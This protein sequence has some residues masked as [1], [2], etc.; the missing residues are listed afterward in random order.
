M[1]NI[2][3]IILCMNRMDMWYARDSFLHYIFFT[4]Y[5]L[6]KM[7]INLF[8]QYNIKSQTK[9][10]VK[11]SSTFRC[12]TILNVPLLQQ[13]FLRLSSHDLYVLNVTQHQKGVHSMQQREC[14]KDV[15]LIY[16]DQ[17]SSSALYKNHKYI[18]YQL[19]ELYT[20]LGSAYHFFCMHYLKIS[21]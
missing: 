11:S 12:T 19:V 4:R 6:S 2:L 1:R 3:A 15:I 17:F 5:L 21:I 20:K 10:G 18:V 16:F 9:I 14:R 7:K 13:V 8:E